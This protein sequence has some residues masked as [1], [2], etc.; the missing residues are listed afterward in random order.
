[1]SWTD[2]QSVK[3]MKYL[4]DK[5]EISDFV[6][7]GT[8][9][10]IN[11]EL[12]SKNF[13]NVYTC[14][15]NEEFYNIAKRNLK[16]CDNVQIFLED[17]PS[18]LHRYTQYQKYIDIPIVD[19]YIPLFYLDA[20]FYDPK[21][22]K[23]KRFVVLDEL[24]ALKNIIGCVIT[25]HDFCNGLGG[26]V[27]DDVPLDFKILEDKLHKINPNFNYYTNQLS[28]CDIVKEDFS[29]IRKAGLEPT[30]DIIESLEYVWSKP[31]KTY[32]GLL[33]A[34]PT[35]LNGNETKM[36]GLREIVSN[37]HGQPYTT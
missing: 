33:Y 18:F 10:G 28:S 35:K 2:R 5:Y 15:K 30:N 12:Q 4:R 34:T 9:V 3:V 21:L 25:I 14:E 29:D 32:R 7:T 20:H 1:M 17:S 19:R 11:A 36:L 37:K 13:K 23:E 22:P 26:L 27:Y 24:D 16:N 8:H 31:E 6:E